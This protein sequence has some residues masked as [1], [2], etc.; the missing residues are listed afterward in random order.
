MTTNML[1]IE[2]TRINN[3]ISKNETRNNPMVLDGLNLVIV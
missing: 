3:Q 1:H 2:K